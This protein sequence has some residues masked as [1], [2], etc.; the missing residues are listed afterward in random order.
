MSID[1]G[2]NRW[3]QARTL[4]RFGSHAKNPNRY[5]IDAIVWFIHSPLT[6][7][8]RLSGRAECVMCVYLCKQHSSHDA[9]TRCRRRRW[10]WWW[11][12]VGYLN[13]Y[14]GSTA[15]Q[16]I[17]H[18]LPIGHTS[19][20]ICYR[21]CVWV[22]AFADNHRQRQCYCMLL[23]CGRRRR[24]RRRTVFPGT[25]I[26]VNIYPGWWNRWHVASS[27]HRRVRDHRGGSLRRHVTART[28][29]TRVRWTLRS[30][31]CADQTRYIVVSP[32]PSVEEGWGMG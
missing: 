3:N 8:Y 30:D 14:T 18:S 28:A 29:R 31:K 10:W 7:C 25:H 16:F 5:T 1:V 9:T 24:R 13:K 21:V 20:A 23:C 4:D 26:Y 6:R 27:S 2:W 22:R 15:A 17:T 11:T 19:F 12:P 32:C